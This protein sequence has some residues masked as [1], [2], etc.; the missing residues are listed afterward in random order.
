MPR[1]FMQ[2]WS[3]A[4]CD[5]AHTQGHSGKPLI[6]TAGRGF[7]R[8]G[9]QPGDLLYI[10]NVLD[11]SVVLV[12]R[13]TV[14]EIL[15]QEEAYHRF[16]NRAWAAPE[17]IVA[18][19]GTATPQFF[20]RDIPNETVR[21]WR[22]VD[23]VRGTGQVEIVRGV[24]DRASLRG[25][26]EIDE[27]TAARIDADLAMPFDAAMDTEEGPIDDEFDMEGGIIDDTSTVTDDELRDIRNRYE[28]P[29]L[30]ERLDTAARTV[31]THA[32]EQDGYTR[33][34]ILPGEES[35]FDIV[36][37]RDGEDYPMICKGSIDD[38][39]SFILDERE[40]MQLEDDLRTIFCIV[41]DVLSETPSAL[42]FNA[43]EFFSY[44]DYR[45]LTYAA[46]YR[47]ME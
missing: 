47:A 27:A 46:T 40:L 20:T 45:G 31:A 11:G 23:D 14:G 17:H 38:P 13:M 32:M 28:N 24:V 18:A 1:Y 4:A 25:L 43:D 39:P 42:F 30:R 34:S 21:L 35:G 15:T 3:N 44:F 33:S 12:G 9:V 8:A 7:L 29:E 10:V 2:Y 37:T 19:E 22:F 36:F 5:D 26:K 41:T 6:Y 16:K